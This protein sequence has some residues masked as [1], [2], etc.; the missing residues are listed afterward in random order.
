MNAI[1][2]LNYEE[3]SFIC[4]VC[5]RD[6]S[7][8]RHRLIP[9]STSKKTERAEVFWTQ[10]KAGARRESPPGGAGES[11]LRAHRTS[12]A[13]HP[14]LDSSRRRR[15]PNRLARTLGPNHRHRLKSIGNRS[16]RRPHSRPRI[17][18]TIK[19]TVSKQLAKITPKPTAKKYN[20]LARRP[21]KLRSDAVGNSL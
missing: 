20:I 2:R 14:C 19:A 11:N 10:A 15:I 1:S 9:R 7:A 13:G 5:G 16:R 18:L 4:L 8:S 12:L 6:W 17:H 21:G 3:I